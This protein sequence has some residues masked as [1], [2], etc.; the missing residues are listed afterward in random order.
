MVRQARALPDTTIFAS[1]AFGSYAPPHAP[2]SAGAL[3]P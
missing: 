3:C 1:V 2:S